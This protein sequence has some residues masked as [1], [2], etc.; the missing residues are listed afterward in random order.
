MLIRFAK[1]KKNK[2]DTLTCVRADGSCTWE[3]SHVGIKHDL[4]HYAVETTLGYQEAFFG[5]V[6]GGRDMS[7]FGTKNGEKDVYTAEEGWAESIVGLLQ[8]P[9]VGGGLPLSDAELLALLTQSCTD[10]G[11]PAPAVTTKQRGQIRTQVRDLHQRWDELPDGEALE[12]FFDA[13]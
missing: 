1:G 8:W 5:L 2:P 12:L 4:I 7:A 6:A 13:R 11:I 9:S 10:A 3:P